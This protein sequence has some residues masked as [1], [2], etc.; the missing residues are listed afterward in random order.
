MF[1]ALPLATRVGK[2]WVSLEADDMGG[3]RLVPIAYRKESR[4]EVIM[5]RRASR[6]QGGGAQQSWEAEMARLMTLND[7]EGAEAIMLERLLQK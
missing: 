3:F 5:P 6:P 7:W 1:L 2:D 4:F